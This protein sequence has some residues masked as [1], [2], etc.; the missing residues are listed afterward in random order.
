[1]SDPS[2]PDRPYPYEEPRPPE[3]A[4]TLPSAGDDRPAYL[5]DPAPPVSPPAQS[6]WG[7]PPGPAAGD[8]TTRPYDSG[9]APVPAPPPAGPAYAPG[10][11]TV[12]GPPVSGPPTSGPPVEPTRP[13]SSGGYPPSPGYAPSP[14]YPPAG[15]YAAPVSGG[16]Y[17]PAPVAMAAP[18]RKGRAGTIVLSIVT[19]FLL[20]GAGALGA[21]FMSTSNKLD[22]T[23]K[24]LTA[25][26]SE[27]DTKIGSQDDQIE[28]LRKD[29]QA[30]K[31]ELAE[32]KQ[33]LTGTQNN[34]EEIKRQKG[35]IVKCLN[36]LAE[37]SMLADQGKTSQARAKLAEANPVCDEADRYLVP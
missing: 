8:E 33:T 15:A 5:S 19:V 11:A 1:M 36:L 18:P 4:Y 31:D 16:P 34:A 14:A 9:P 3:P 10:S 6:G 28:Q 35:V 23:E 7:T 27:R 25:Q 2:S 17:A 29:L 24:T 30:S 22:R 37:A 13:M 26:V 20:L 12:G 32:T 21:L